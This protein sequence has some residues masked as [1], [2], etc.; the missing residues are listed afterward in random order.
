[1]ILLIFL[2]SSLRH[3]VCQLRLLV[4]VGF[5]CPKNIV[6]TVQFTGISIS[7]GISI[8]EITDL[9]VQNTLLTTI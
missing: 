2:T 8:E 7:S 3:P 6:E 5:I 1:L 4:L 9:E